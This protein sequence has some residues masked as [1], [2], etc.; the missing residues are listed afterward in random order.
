MNQKPAKKLY[1]LSEA[2][3][4]LSIS[5]ATGRNWIK[6]GRLVPSSCSG[7]KNVFTEAD[8]LVLK[9]ALT[10]G[11]VPG[12]KGRRNKTF[13]DGTSTYSSY[14]E[15]DSANHHALFQ[16]LHTIHKEAVVVD[17][18]LLFCLLRHCAMQL[19][20]AAGYRS[21]ELFEE[22][23]TD[24]ICKETFDYFL[25][26]HPAIFAVSYTYYPKED[27]LGFLYLSL[28]NIQNRKLSGSYYTP[29]WLAK[30][31]VSNH[32]PMI[33]A[34]KTCFDP[35]CG[36]G[37]FLLQL[38]EI[39]P[40]KNIYG[41]DLNPISVT[42]A[43]INLALKYHLTTK[44][45]VTLL[46]NNITVA[47]FL[48]VSPATYDII[49]GN[50]P[51]GARISQEKKTTYRT[52]YLCAGRSSIEIFDLFMEQ[53][54]NCLL[55]SGVLSFVLPQALLTVKSHT[56]VRELLLKH[57][58]VLSVEYLGEAFE[59]VNCPSIILT[60]TKNRNL[61][62]FR[63]VSVTLEN[64]TVFSTFVE[65]S[66][67]A[68]CFSFSLTDEEYLTL[69]KILSCPKCT[70][71]VDNS[72]FALGIVTGNNAALLHDTPATG[73]EPVIRGLDISKYHIHS[74]SGYLK[75]APEQFQQT[76]PETY[77]RAPEKLFYR[78]INKQ[79]TFAYDDT[80]LLSLNSCNILIPKIPGLSIKYVMA[81]LNS[82]VAQFV[83]EKKFH[84]VKV[85]R[86]HLEQIPIPLA[87]EQTQKEVVELVDLLL[88]TEETSSEYQATYA[89]LDQKIANLFC[90]TR[91][92]YE[93][94]CSR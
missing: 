6:S 79:L 85:L 82:S 41:T 94:I 51:W 72:V 34:S 40:L 73:L 7:K 93:L 14:I 5:T 46:K 12:L 48:E 13:V 54:I 56:P 76:A 70:T 37:M 58:S 61:P 16:L 62:F 38:P 25:A 43:R 24:C 55:P 67:Q 49:L 30:R 86:S 90:L 87:K 18:T 42:L 1:T 60:V 4:L 50:P 92:E 74:C 2:C 45:E 83:F 63:D 68:D 21:P 20:A 75:F 11:R 81:I 19:I 9:Q 29:V 71:L 33:D 57:T 66:I 44:E 78:F 35:S 64:R 15:K 89:H 91:Q 3:E 27:T 39:F 8:L 59:Q 28:Q 23:L 32:L 77:Y 52:K 10:D 65:R 69:Q 84:S 88:N 17:E 22:F 53:A 31:L 36:T 26:K 80:G 47:D